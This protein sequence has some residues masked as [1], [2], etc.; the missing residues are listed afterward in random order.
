MVAM[1]SQL[2]EESRSC[3]ISV[4]RLATYERLETSRASRERALVWLAHGETLVIIQGHVFYSISI[5][6]ISPISRINILMT[7]C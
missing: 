7:I 5:K 4:K 6:L 2:D 1:L 3:S